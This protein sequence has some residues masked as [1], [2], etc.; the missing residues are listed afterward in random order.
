MP[1][2]DHIIGH[3]Q[4]ISHLE[5][6]IAL[7]KISHAYLLQGEKGSGKHTVA[8]AFAM[9]LQCEN[10]E[11]RPCGECRSCHQAENGNHPDIITVTHEK[12][13]S[14]GVDEIR[15]QLV[16]DVQIK[17]YSGKYKIYIV[18]DAEKMTV[19]AQNA[20]LKTIEEPPEY[21]VILLLGADSSAFLDTVL[22]RCVTLTLRPVPDEQV[23]EYLMEHVQIPDYQADICVAF[24]QGNIGKAIQ[25]A[26]SEN[27]GQIKA[28]AV[29]LVKNVKNMDITEIIQTVKMVY[30][31]KVDIRDYLD[32]LAVWYRDVLYFK[33]TKDIDGVIFKDQL[34]YIREN[35]ETSSYE[36]I[37]LILEGIQKAKVRLGANVNFDLTMELLFL[38][39]SCDCRDGQG[40]GVRPG[41]RRNTGGRRGKGHSA[42]K[43]GDPCGYARG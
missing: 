32:I 13:N 31:Y 42:L 10:G 36:G 37:E 9:A 27:F 12:P 28:S 21:A 33:A 39:R 26:S 7:G 25:L 8:M 17:P 15:D 40:R 11:K 14:I 20:L 23:K 4:V 29:Q 2:F 16:S 30:E 34:R 3:K 38:R 19:Q 35:A 6:A 5:R 41:G 24:A 22:S 1:G 43:A 18:P